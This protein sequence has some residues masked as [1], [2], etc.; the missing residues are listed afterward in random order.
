MSLKSKLTLRFLLGAVVI[1]AILF[2]P[3]GS[4]RFWQGWAYLMA[5]FVPTLFGFGYFC[6][7]DPKLVERRLPH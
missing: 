3:A 4:L 7:H 2:I 5:W 1:A 6:K